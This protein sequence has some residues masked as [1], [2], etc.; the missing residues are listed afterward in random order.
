MGFRAVVLETLVHEGRLA[1]DES[2]L[3]VCAGESDVQILSAC[4]FGDVTYT[5][6]DLDRG[7]RLH[8]L[9]TETDVHGSKWQEADAHSLP[10]ADGSFAGCLVADGLHHC[11]MPHRV[12]TEMY[13]V[14]RRS[15]VVIESRD[16]LLMRGASRLGLTAPY[17]I[18]GRLLETRSAGGMN[19]GP[20]PNFVYRWTE[21]DFEKLLLTFDPA[22]RPLFE[23]FYGVSL[24]PGL[25]GTKGRVLEAA[26]EMVRRVAP[27]Q[28]NTFAMVATKPGTTLQ[29]YLQDGP[30]GAVL[31]DDVR[32][33]GDV[34]RVMRQM[35]GPDRSRH[36]VRI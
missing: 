30:S 18:N 9:N 32:T 15:V 28:G 31:R 21:R 11:Q 36:V 10:F 1:A 24:P 16:S 2:L 12:V 35:N 13:R 4:G 8:G 27:R 25:E 14:A 17:E 22:H 34:A 3:V 19:F 7:T 33:P 20:V 23:Y 5:N 26:A 6:I 29:P